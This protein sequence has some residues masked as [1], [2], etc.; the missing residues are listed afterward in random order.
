MKQDVR[1]CIKYD[2]ATPVPDL[3]YTDGYRPSDGT[4]MEDVDCMDVMN[5]LGYMGLIEDGNDV[6]DPS[7]IFQSDDDQTNPGQRD[8]RILNQQVPNEE[9][10][11]CYI[12]EGKKQVV[13]EKTG[14]DELGVMFFEWL[15]NNKEHIS[16][17]DMRNI[18]F[19]RAT[20]E[21]ASKRLGSTKEGRK[22]LLKLILEW[23]E[24]YHLQ[25]KRNGDAA[26][27]F[28]QVPCQCQESFPNPNP[29][30]KNYIPT[31]DANTFMWIPTPQTYI[32]HQAMV[33]PSFFGASSISTGT[34]YGLC[35]LVIITLLW[36]VV[37]L[38]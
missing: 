8:Q 11:S 37:R 38:Q 25:N 18:K 31:T 15:K 34:G 27:A 6:W 21:C 7:C 16:A 24:Q 14:L 33:A 17:E 4:G 9:D 19:K 2:V 20:I 22:Q 5:N 3:S 23:V 1:R 35:R 28:H 32:D 36:V 30:I 13:E 12:L 29:N 26:A 10:G